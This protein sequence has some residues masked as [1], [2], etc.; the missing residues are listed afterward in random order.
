VPELRVLDAQGEPLEAAYGVDFTTRV[1]GAPLSTGELS[2]L[3]VSSLEDLPREADPEVALVLDAKAG[4]AKRW[5]AERGAELGRGWGLAVRLGS[6][7]PG[8]PARVPRSAFGLITAPLTDEPEELTVRGELRDVFANG[9]AARLQLVFHGSREE[10]TDYNVVG[11]IDGVGTPDRPELAQEV[12]V[13]S[14]HYDHV[15]TRPSRVAGEPDIVFNGADDD[16]SGVATVLELAEAF[17]AA[18]APAR[19]LVFLLATGEERGILGTKHYVE[20]P[21]LPLD[22]TVCNLNFEMLGRPDELVGGSGKLW[23][24]GYERTTLGPAFA[25]RG[26]DVVADRRLEQN[27]FMRSDNIVFVQ[28]GIVG[29]TLSTYNMHKDYHQPTDDADTLDY[30]HMQACARAGF[31]AAKLLSDGVISPEWNEGEPRMGRGR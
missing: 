26:I 12:I 17:R 1:R 2:I 25:E 30:E 5:L 4:E 22:K 9:G 14:A 29:Q 20:H 16:A 10:I 21:P 11:R 19:T 18:S 3:V 31:L 23:L 13:L 24:S 27:F 15:G 7:K 28:K 8:R 6:A